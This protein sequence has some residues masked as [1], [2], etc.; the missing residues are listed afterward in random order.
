M[1]IHIGAA[2][3]LLLVL[4]AGC[5]GREQP[6]KET[7]ELFDIYSISPSGALKFDGYG[8]LHF[9]SAETDQWTYLC[10]KPGCLHSDSSC[11]AFWGADGVNRA[12]FYNGNLYVF[13]QDTL[14]QANAYGEE[15]RALGKTEALPYLISA[16]RLDG[17]RVYYIG[18]CWNDTSNTAEMRLC[19]MDLADGTY[20][21][22]P[23]PDN[24]YE[25]RTLSWYHISGNDSYQFYVSTEV[26]LHDFFDPES[27]ELTEG[28]KDVIPICQLY[29]TD[30]VTGE[31]EL[32]LERESPRNAGSALE[33]VA[34]HDGLLTLIL[35]G[36]AVDY[37]P[38][39][40]KTT[41]L[42]D[43]SAIAPDGWSKIILLGDKQIVCAATSD[44]IVLDH[45][46][47]TGSPEELRETE[48]I[49]M[50]GDKI[51]FF[52]DTVHNTR[53]AYLLQ[54]DW[55]QGRYVFHTAEGSAP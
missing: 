15:R 45:W 36:T 37:D 8:Y 29:R 31:S 27:Q 42:A 22:L 16:I 18:E 10:N 50:C 17:G 7:T 11:G 52:Y 49:G 39:T 55:D 21:E 51:F 43:M 54:E 2:L 24:G 19:R 41:P 46:Q 40:G 44:P 33:P 32:L 3:L 38:A 28:W 30:L 9:C 4:S 47:V 20:E 14:Y 25:F 26:N 13:H 53:L 12:F 23:Q 48:P 35:D 5:G 6:L 34:F 1:K